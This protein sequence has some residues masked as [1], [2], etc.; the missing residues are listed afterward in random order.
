VE[1][2]GPGLFVCD[3]VDRDHTRIHT[4]HVHNEP[5]AVAF[6]TAGAHLQRAIAAR[7]RVDVAA[8]I[9]DGP[10]GKVAVGTFAKGL[11]RLGTRRCTTD[12]EADV[13]AALQ[14]RHVK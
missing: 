9:L 7:L 11:T 5:A 10:V 1:R 6:T 3:A 12:V 2:S 14:T 4:R 8:R 13:R